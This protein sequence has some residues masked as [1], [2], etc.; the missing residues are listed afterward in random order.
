[1]EKLTGGCPAYVFELDGRVVYT[2]SS[3]EFQRGPC[4]NLKNGSEVEVR[5][6]LMSDGRVRADRIRYED[7]DD[8]GGVGASEND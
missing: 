8:F 7:N 2:T 1:M 3:T 6:T 4:K 5:G